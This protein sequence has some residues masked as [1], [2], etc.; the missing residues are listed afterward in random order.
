MVQSKICG[1][2]PKKRKFMVGKCVKPVAEMG[3]NRE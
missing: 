1:G 2:N 3:L